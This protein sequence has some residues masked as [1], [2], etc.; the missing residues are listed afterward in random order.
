MLLPIGTVVEAGG[1]KFLTVGYIDMGQKEAP[2]L[3]YMMV[4]YPF[5]YLRADRVT[6][7]RS[8]SVEEVLAEGYI[9]EKV[10]E[11]S[12]EEAEQQEGK[13]EQL[14]PIGSIVELEE[15]EDSRYMVAGYY[16]VNGERTG[17]Y[18]AV[19]YPGGIR[20]TKELCMLDKES[21]EKVLWRGYLDE[22]GEVLI[23]QIPQFMQETSELMKEFSETLSFAL[24]QPRNSMEEE[25]EVSVIME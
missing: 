20:Q 16:P 5:G 12:V 7:C 4:S 14:L 1:Q 22:E 9:E 19:P 10:K 2:A 3:G 6:A 21:I 24:R 11:E 23:R 25:D 15:G 13:K 17:D 8:D 18:V